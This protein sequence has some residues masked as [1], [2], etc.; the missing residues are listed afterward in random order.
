MDR[1]PELPGWPEG[2]AVVWLPADGYTAVRVQA[3]S[4]Q[5]AE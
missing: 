1:R 2:E 5:T 3:L 4:G